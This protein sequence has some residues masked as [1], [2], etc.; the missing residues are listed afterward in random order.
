[1]VGTITTPPADAN[2]PRQQASASSRHDAQSD[3]LKEAHGV[4]LTDAIFRDSSSLPARL[5][6]AIERGEGVDLRL[7]E[8]AAAPT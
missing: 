7:V 2:Q 1:M 6:A 8:G 4:T 5:V 3:H